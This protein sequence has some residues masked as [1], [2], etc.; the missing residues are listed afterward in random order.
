MPLYARKRIEVIIEAPAAALV[1][2]LF[3]R[4]QVSGF[5]VVTASAGR[6]RTSS[7]DLNPVTDAQQQVIVIAILGEERAVTLVEAIGALLEDY[8]GIVALSTVEVLQPARF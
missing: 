7:W 5:T 4:F 6:G 8:H 2:D 1:L 3:D